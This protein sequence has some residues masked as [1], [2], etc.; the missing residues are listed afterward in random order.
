MEN[1]RFDPAANPMPFYDKRMIYGGFS[2]PW[3]N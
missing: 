2:S 1:P 3:W